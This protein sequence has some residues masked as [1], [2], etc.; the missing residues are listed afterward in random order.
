MKRVENLRFY[1]LIARLN[2][3]Y[4]S[5]STMLF[6]NAL[7][8]EHLL[9]EKQYNELLKKQYA[10]APTPAKMHQT[11]LLTGEWMQDTLAFLAKRRNYD[12]EKA[13]LDLVKMNSH[14][15]RTRYINGIYETILN[16]LEGLGK[17]QKKI[18][19]DELFKK[20]WF[21]VLRILR[22]NASHFDNFGKITLWYWPKEEEIKWENIIIKKSDI[23]HEIR[24]NDYEIISLG[25]ICREYFIDR[26]YQFDKN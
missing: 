4:D 16:F 26:E 10:I 19:S 15:L 2:E 18:V 1:T 7:L 24:Y 3:Y 11:I 9:I 14:F 23:G 22:D 20:S 12:I 25:N 21:K 6:A 13:K 8:Y 17:E 5:Y